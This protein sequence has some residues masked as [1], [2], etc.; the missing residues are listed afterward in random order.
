MIK[1]INFYKRNITFIVIKVTKCILIFVL[2]TI[3]M[4]FNYEEQLTKCHNI[5]KS[6]DF[7]NVEI[8]NSIHETIKQMEFCSSS[9]KNTSFRVLVTGSLKLV[10]GVLEVLSSS[11]NY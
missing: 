1:K 4:N 3:D 7:C 5:K 2:D 8:Y 10:G 6:I 9:E 11:M